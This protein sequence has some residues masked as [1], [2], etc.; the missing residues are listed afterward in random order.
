MAKA[1]E[2]D[3]SLMIWLPEVVGAV[4]PVEHPA[5]EIARTA[6]RIMVA[7]FRKILLLHGMRISGI[8]LIIPPVSSIGQIGGKGKRRGENPA[9]LSGGRL[10]VYLMSGFFSDV[11]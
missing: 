6:A 2:A 4:V 7:S 5:K 8:P 10:Q 3:I 1:S 11:L 9:A